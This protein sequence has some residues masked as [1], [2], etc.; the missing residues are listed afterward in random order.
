MLKHNN[1]NNNNNKNV[2]YTIPYNNIIGNIPE[3]SKG[4]DLR[5]GAINASRVRIPLLPPVQVSN[6]IRG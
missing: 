6:W 2:V 1:N 3:R 4:S 5:S